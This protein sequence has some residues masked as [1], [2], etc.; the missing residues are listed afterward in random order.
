MYSESTGDMVVGSLPAVDA[1]IA[2]APAPAPSLGSML[3]TALGGS[4][5][6]V[7]VAGVTAGG[8]TTVAGGL[9]RPAVPHCHQ[10]ANNPITISKKR[11]FFME[12]LVAPQ[13]DPASRPCQSFDHC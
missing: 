8:A 4:A 9:D 2:A 5:V 7:D 3:S 10:A 11:N 1:A 13:R 12:H 6:G